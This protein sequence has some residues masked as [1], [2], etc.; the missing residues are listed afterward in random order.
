MPKAKTGVASKLR[1]S[2][3]RVQEKTKPRE[4][5][6]K[7]P[8]V[9]GITQSMLGRFLMC[10]ERFR[11]LVVDG[12]RP[13]DQF[14]HRIEYGQ[15]WHTC[16]EYHAQGQAWEG[17]LKDYA[18]GLRKRYPM[19]SVQVQHWYEVC[20]H[21]FPLYVKYWENH[22]DVK[23]REPLFQEKSF[24]VPYALPSGRNVILRGKWDGV[25]LIGP[26]RRQAV[27]LQEN[28]TKGDI[29]EEQLQRQ[30][31]F[32]M[33]TMFYLVALREYGKVVEGSVPRPIGGVRY[34][35]VRRP[36]SGGKGSI[37]K[38]Q[39]SKANPQG[40]SDAQFYQRLE[41]IIEE[42]P[43][44]FFMRWRA[45]IS[46]DDME[47]FEERFLRPIL[48]SLCDWW[49]FVEGRHRLGEPLYDPLANRIHWQF[50]YGLYNVLAEG[51]STELDEYIATGS[52]LGL[53]RATTLFRELE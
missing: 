50:P 28:K 48:E 19:Q 40:E 13:A 23:N 44:Y 51:G 36:L 45:E 14:N 3:K 26:K 47:K 27:Y 16:E 22:P 46:L 35:V 11:I 20:R 33:Q 10:R 41:G 42:D 18:A 38:H 2:M 7:G 31:S 49:S 34:N 24:A 8:E 43:G 17:P 12:L 6:W 15:M 25:D 4:P 52:T 21:Q 9:D 53:E 37:R 5:L 32:D 30:L 29:H 1:G 39:P